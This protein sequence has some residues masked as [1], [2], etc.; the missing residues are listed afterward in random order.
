M[1]SYLPNIIS[2]NQ[3]GY[4]KG[5]YIG[6]NIRTIYDLLHLTEEKKIP[7]Q[8]MLIDF[9][10]AFD[11]VSWKFLYKTLS[12]FGFDKNFI[13]WIKLL[14]TN[15]TAFVLQCGSLSEPIE[16]GRGCRQGDPISPYLF[17]LVAEILSVMIL[18]ND[19]I[20]GIQIGSHI[21][22][23]TQFADDTTLLLN[24]SQCS[25]Q[26]SINILELFGSLSG[27]RM[28]TEKTKVIW[29]ES[30][31][32]CKEK[33]DVSKKL[34]WGD[35]NF[36]F[37]GVS[38]SSNIGTMSKVNFQ[39]ILNKAKQ[40]LNSWQ[41]RHLTPFGKVTIIKT[42]ILSK[43]NHLFMTLVTPEHILQELNAMFFKFLWNGKSHK[44]KKT[45]ICNDYLCGGLRMINV[46]EFERSLKLS[47][48][49]RILHNENSPW[50]VLLQECCGK[51]ERLFIL[52]PEWC[53]K[54]I[55][56]VNPFWKNV[57]LNWM[58]FCRNLKIKSQEDVLSNSIWC[59]N[60][61]WKDKNYVIYPEWFKCGITVVADLLNTEGCFISLEELKFRYKLQVNILNYFSMKRNIETFFKKSNVYPTTVLKRPHIPFHVKVLLEQ[62][63]GTKPFYDKLLATQSQRPTSESKWCIQLNMQFEVD[64]W[65][66]I[67][68]ICFKTIFDN[69]YI[70]FQFRILHKILGTNDY[71]YK[72]NIQNSSNCG[73][74]GLEPETDTHLFMMCEKVLEL[75]T[76]IKTWIKRK[77]FICI[78]I[79]Q[80]CLILGYLEMDENFWPLNFVLLITRYYIFNCSR[81]QSRLDIFSLQKIVKEKYFEQ[82]NPQCSRWNIKHIQQK[83]DTL[84]Y[85]I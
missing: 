21:Y 27:L 22:K 53:Q 62:E 51:L 85:A 68:K 71:L 3:T 43:F 1:K 64:T 30:K 44:V 76:N 36:S 9:E 82:K 79:P 23:I 14:N 17:L 52:G 42:L 65:R 5:R 32:Q 11:S 19:N 66:L 16:V 78:D 50:N 63:K 57:F 77:L 2:K 41:S 48:I 34:H 6:E 75:W 74:C 39:I 20:K 47:W 37:L 73:I 59:N 7:G 38:F 40:V 70:W 4:I 49:K 56:K 80:Y 54:Y 10:K 81:N 18:N 25:L 55:P 46:Y 24:G 83:V 60:K 72:L 26:T 69:S 12:L 61:I 58:N 84:E 28:N 33:L 29:I 8:I 35:S 13:N 31:K 15:I 45:T 67:Y